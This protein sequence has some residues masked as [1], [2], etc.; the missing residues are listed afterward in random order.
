MAPA[1]FVSK[2]LHNV[3]WQDID[4]LPKV[5]EAVFNWWCFEVVIIPVNLRSSHWVSIA[6]DKN[7]RVTNGRNISLSCR[8]MNSL[9]LYE[10]EL[11]GIMYQLQKYLAMQYLACH[12]VLVDISL[13]YEFCHQCPICIKHTDSRSCGIYMFVFQ[14][15][16]FWG[17]H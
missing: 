15:S 17:K 13:D 11:E 4:V 1:S 6:I 7:Q 14:S 9:Q 16:P 12:G 3:C 10:M 5:L 2:E 8:I